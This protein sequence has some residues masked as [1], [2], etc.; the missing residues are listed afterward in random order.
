MR[1]PT[2]WLE[3]AAAFVDGRP[4]AAAD[5]YGGS[6]AGRTRRTPGYARPRD[7]A[8]EGRA[9]EADGDLRR[10]LAFYRETGARRYL[11]EA[12]PLTAAL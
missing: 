9:A 10:A 1:A 7:L 11:A 12:E 3:A 5:I 2:R 4:Q 6:A 8:G